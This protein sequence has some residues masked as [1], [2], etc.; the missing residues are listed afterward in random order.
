MKMMSSFTIMKRK[1]LVYGIRETPQT[2]LSLLK[3]ILLQM[4]QRK[5][6]LGDLLSASIS[7]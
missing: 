4:I 6:G 3:L 7:L 5:E 2:A 1:L